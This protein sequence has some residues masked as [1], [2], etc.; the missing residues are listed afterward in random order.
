MMLEDKIN[1]YIR[2]DQHV[3]AFSDI[4]VVQWFGEPLSLRYWQFIVMKE[5][6]KVIEQASMVECLTSPSEYV[7][8]YKMHLKGEKRNEQ[9]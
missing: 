3:F 7:R 1:E 2:R 5:I 4:R 9:C 6:D 8:G